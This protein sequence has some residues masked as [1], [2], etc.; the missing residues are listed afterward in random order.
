VA[1][2]TWLAKRVVLPRAVVEVASSV[3]GEEKNDV[4]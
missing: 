2:G 1:V 4:R 3:P